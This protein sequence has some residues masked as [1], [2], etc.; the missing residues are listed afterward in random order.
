MV[1]RRSDVFSRFLVAALLLLAAVP[2][3]GQ[4][5]QGI[6]VF[7]A[8]DGGSRQ[9]LGTVQISVQ[10]TG[11]GGLTSAEGSLQLGVPAGTHTVEA[12]RIG[13]QTVRQQV[14]VTSG[15]TV[16]V[17]VE[18]R[19]T[20]LQLQ[21]IVVT[22]LVDPMEG[23]R[24][25]ISV[26]HV[27][28]EMMPVIA[29]GNAIQNLQ[30]RLPSVN[31]ARASGQPGSG[32][33]MVLR[34]PTSLMG[35]TAPLVVVDGVILG[36]Q[37]IPSTTD[38]DS[39]DIESVEVIRG[40]AASS[41][42]GSRAASGVISIKTKRG[43][44]LGLGET[45]FTA[46]SEMGINQNLRNIQL[47]DHH[48]FLMNAD[49]TQYVNAAGVVV[50]RAQRVPPALT[51]AFMDKPYPGPVYDNV[52]AITRAGQF[53]TNNFSVSG[54][55]QN[56][57]FAVSLNNYQEG[58]SL[59]GN[60][61]YER[62]AFRVNLDHRFVDALNL[63]VSVYHS[64]DNRDNI[65]GNP[66]N[67][68]L[69]APRDIDFSLRDE[70][71][72]YLQQ[73]DPNVIYQNPLWTNATR[74]L[75]QKSTRTLANVGLTWTPLNWLSGSAS[76]GYDRSDSETRN[77]V[78]KGTPLNVGQDGVSDGSLSFDNDFRDTYNGEASVSFKRDFGGLNVR[79]TF[80]GLMERENT[81]SGS[82]SGSN[83]ILMGIPQ[84]NNIRAE[85]RSATSSE[86]EI[87]SLGYL[88]ETASDYDG[89]YIVSVLGRRDGSSLFGVDNRWANY[90]RVAGAWRMAEE[91]WF[92]VPNVS[93][94]KLSFAQGTAGGRP[95]VTAQYE[96]WT[97]SGGI[98]TKGTLG[99]T[100][101][102]PEHTTERE[103]SLNAVLF[104]NFGL[105]VTHARQRTVDQ[106]VQSP[107]PAITGYTTQWV[108]SGTV[109]GHSTEV[110]LEMQLVQAQKIGWTTMIV[111][112]YSN[113][114]IEEWPLP[115][116]NAQA[117]R[118]LCTGVPAYGLYSRWLVKS[119]AQLN[120][121]RGGDALGNLDEFEVNDEGFLV[122][123]G[124]GNHY[125]EGQSKSLWGT[126]S[127]PIGG[128]VYQWGHPFYE[129]TNQ[130]LP[131]R[132]LLGET[133]PINFGWINN[134]R[135]G[136][137]TVYT[138]VQT[139]I[140]GDAN[141]RNHQLMANTATATAPRMDQFG[142]PTGL[143]K[144]IQYFRS[145]LDGDNSYS[146]EDASYIKLRT[147]S[148]AYQMPESQLGRLGFS[149]AGIKSLQLGAIVRNVFTLSN[150]DG[151]DPEQAV[152]L[153]TRENTDGGTYPP[154][155]SLTMQLTVTF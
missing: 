102:K 99:N 42:Y 9:P 36:G 127:Q 68:A 44:S 78:P 48:H 134:V 133:N 60:E 111:A 112:D 52:S 116:S 94:L 98:P 55:A 128:K 19:E 105:V 118:Y 66:F 153:N 7:R 145:A 107:L 89:K 46:S 31:V 72:N 23:V 24:A 21:G 54:N 146:V 67:E 3:A 95:S 97:L 69:R 151:F 15:S 33:T 147:V 76:I 123:V 125:W 65:S 138:Q 64:R 103:W 56:T 50:P 10:G 86:R 85:D 120:Q 137:F 150:Y 28:R 115:C 22:G 132:T 4:A 73:P 18:L 61:G 77:Y 117:W 40:A 136:A 58:G 16:T 83:F 126:Q 122:W 129:E 101:L 57:N 109:S 135:V 47:N 108:N 140:G 87:R 1:A 121:H 71:G 74:D 100:H 12:T 75:S 141:N 119:H 70:N 155:R 25:P 63:G 11:R 80:R 14:T 82:R 143:K 88:W 81:E 139:S 29:A 152:N 30:G 131:N 106:L 114:R 62:N 92:N 113:S 39:N 91:S 93:E 27:D 13:Y 53:M 2:L 149:R 90:Y 38:I 96:T 17:N 35:N 84:L 148:A 130:K 32:V 59:V 6:V 45:T 51:V 110:T 26:A 144:P 79:T 154:T 41:L 43:S 124:K 8:I 5:G 142:K 104:E 20:T 37:G 49:M 34:T